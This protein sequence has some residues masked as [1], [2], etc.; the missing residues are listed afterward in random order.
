[1]AAAAAVLVEGPARSDVSN[2]MVL[3]SALMNWAEPW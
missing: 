1:M 3:P 2:W